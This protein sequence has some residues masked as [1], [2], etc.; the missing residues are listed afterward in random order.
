M[1][2]EDPGNLLPLAKEVSFVLSNEA[3]NWGFKWI[4]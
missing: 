1:I 3:T 4:N 2:H